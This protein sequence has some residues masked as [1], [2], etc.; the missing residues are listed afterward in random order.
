MKRAVPPT[1][2]H[3]L[4][5]F[6]VTLLVFLTSLNAAEKK[7]SV[8]QLKNSHIIYSIVLQDSGL[9]Q[10]SLRATSSSPFV[11]S[12][13]FSFIIQWSG[14]RAPGKDNNAENPVSLSKLQF[15]W[16]SASF[17]TLGQVQNLL[18]NFRGIHNPFH[19]SIQYRL[20][21]DD[22]FLRKRLII[23]DPSNRS[24]FLHKTNLILTDLRQV[25]PVKTGGFGQ[26]VAFRIGKGGIFLGIEY[27][28]ATTILKKKNK[29][30]FLKGFELVGERIDSAGVCTSWLVIGFAEDG[31][32]KRAFWQYL[33]RIRVAPL[34]PYLLYNSWYD[35]RAPEMV[36]DPTAVMNEENVRR[37]I[38]LFR[39]N[40]IQPFGI[41]FDAF[42][43]DD[44]WDIY[45]SDWQ[46]NPDQFPNGLVPIAEELEKDSTHLGIWY[47]PIGGYSHRNWRVGWMKEQGYETVGTQMCLAGKNYFQLFKRRVL[48][49]VVNDGIRYFKWDGIQFSCNE[50]DHGHPIGLYSRRAILK[51]VAELCKTVR[52]A[53]PEVFLN[54]TSGTWLSPWWLLYANQIWMQ[55]YDYGY[56]NVPSISKRDAAM[57]YRD[58][59]LYDDF[60]RKGFWFPIA[61]LMTHG[62]IKGNL[63]KLGGETEPL[64]KFTDNAVLYFARGVSMWEL[65]ISPDLLTDGEWLAIA[66][67]IRWAKDRFPILMNTEMIGGDPGNREAYGYVHFRGDRGIV[68]ARNPYIEPAHLR[69]P[70]S[71]AY[72]LNPRANS[73][74]VEQ[75]YPVRRFLPGIYSEGGILTL[76]LSG[77]ETAV[78][79]I[80]PLDQAPL[81]V[82]SGVIITDV[83]KQGNAYF[84]T[85]AR[86]KSVH[87][88][89]AERIQQIQLNGKSIALPELADALRAARNG[90]VWAV[91]KS[92]QKK[93]DRRMFSVVLNLPEES[94]KTE[95]AVLLETKA[96]STVSDFPAC[97]VKLDG[98]RVP[99]SLHEQKRA[100]RWLK[101]KVDPSSRNATIQIKLDR[102]SAGWHGKISLWL[103][104]LKQLA[105]HSVTIH[106]DG[107]LSAIRPPL[108]SPWEQGYVRYHQKLAEI[109]M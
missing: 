71:A 50:P 12:G 54:I 99:S 97:Q 40:M 92:M 39:K 103:V 58:Y 3:R 84:L 43:L 14:W 108:P 24:H 93:S 104:G 28:A 63:Q 1:P 78:Y 5:F 42:V 83:K 4:T 100:W 102:S 73:L 98:K 32:I 35:L 65:Y 25:T 41:H 60:R 55:G 45:R 13:D 30:F 75:I 9:Y 105:T 7:Q 64:D 18:L 8:F 6:V 49:N 88:L 79:E 106:T 2:L 62:I 90:D 51:A 67:S 37:I 11:H 87:L 33:D 77:Y 95:I 31:H 16:V 15:K 96:Q 70:L 36:S 85:L 94:R 74:I 76:E 27:P 61:N 80:Y 56:A 20:G 44:G 86:G 81:P 52:L 89:N 91:V 69:V 109:T 29:G 107:S 82:I 101:F 22:F 10:E 72:G 34:R 19:L 48:D 47:G 26:P 21:K 46:L 38:G 66:Q 59:V 57:T 23:K 68:A 17:D 53:S